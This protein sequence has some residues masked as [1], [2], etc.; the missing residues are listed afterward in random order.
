[1]GFNGGRISGLLLLLSVLGAGGAAA[2]DRISFAS[3]LP[4]TL[5][6]INE[7]GG[8]GIATSEV[9]QQ[10]RD[11]GFPLVDPALAASAAQR[12]LVQQA[13]GGDQ[14]AAVQLGRDFGAHV[15]IL[16]NAEWGTAPNPIAAGTQTGTADVALRAIRLDEGEVLT[17]RSGNGRTFDATEQGARTAAIRLAVKE[18]MG[19]EFVGRVANNW[20]ERP[21][22]TRGY[23]RPDPGSLEAALTGP[24]SAGAPKL[25]IIR[26]EVL[27]AAGATTGSRGIGIVVRSRG[28]NES[29]KNDVNVQ[30]IVVGQV[31]QVE[32]EGIRATLSPVD[33]DTRRQFGLT[34]DA[35]WFNA[36]I[37]LPLSQ[38][39]INV[40]ARSVTGEITTATAAA[41][42][43]Q[44][45]AVVIGVGEYASSSIPDLRYAAK[46]AQ[47]FYDFL[48]S[49]AAGPFP[50][51]NIIFLKDGQATA[52]AMREALFVFLQKP[53]YNDLVVIYFAG[54]G[55]PDHSM[56]ENLYLLPTDADVSALAST[57]VPM[58]DVKTAL[59]RQIRAERVVVIADAC[60]SGGTR[61]GVE[62]PIGGA[63]AELFSPSRRLTLTAAADNEQSLEDAKWGGGHGVFTWNILEA[64]KG[65]GDANGDGIV[66]FDEVSTYVATRVR[67]ETGNRQNPQRSGLGDVPLAVVRAAN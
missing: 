27:P 47:A 65:A 42:I 18:L 13:L 6:F 34:G 41:R 61:T 60:H 51:E 48:R 24:I 12:D 14:Q 39:T 58:W 22:A 26:T 67:S 62:N 53:E 1:M 17:S 46:D 54:H 4:R 25:A 66:T 31:Q 63:F 30:G 16:G 11:M 57:A 35:Q 8:A 5:V 7:Q 15:I 40:A 28:G 45:Y 55:A 38:D 10:L 59:R 19:T 44:R 9:T 52:Q 29:A 2:Q 20:T 3:Q 43:G 23:F 32:V 50:E 49:D 64:L 21:W 56:P 37:S 36:R 33:A